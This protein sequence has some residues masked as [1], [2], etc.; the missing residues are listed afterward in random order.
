M[1]GDTGILDKARYAGVVLKTRRAGDRFE[2][3][4]QGMVWHLGDANG[5]GPIVFKDQN[6]TGGTNI[7]TIFDSSTGDG[8]LDRAVTK[9][10]IS[11]AGVSQFVGWI[12]ESSLVLDAV[13]QV[14]SAV[15]LT[16]RVNPNG[17]IDVSRSTSNAVY[18]YS[19]TAVDVVAVRRGWG[20]DPTYAGAEAENVETVTDASEWVSRSIIVDEN[21]NG[22][23]SIHEWKNR[24]VNPYANIHNTPLI[25][26]VL[27]S[28]AA[29]TTGNSTGFINTRLAEN[30][31]RDEFTLKTSQWEFSNSNLAVGD[32]VWVYDPPELTDTGKQIN[33][34]GQFINPVKDRVTEGEW[35]VTE[36]MGV[37]YRP[38]ST[39]SISS[40]DYVDLTPF[41]RWEQ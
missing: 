31:V 17:T 18:K 1:F 2:I 33:F 26:N 35:P 22:S 16:W 11:T 28:R 19:D 20:S 12:E 25:R 14:A 27:D 5:R 39:S 6:Y 29:A 36:G 41:V 21:A 30:D 23:H 8:I 24:A 15:D 3:E 7:A 13:R 38:T 9:G 4:G 34:R 40:T 10:T 37:Y 32:N